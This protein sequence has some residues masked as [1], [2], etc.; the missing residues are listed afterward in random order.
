ME[1]KVFKLNELI[2]PKEEVLRYLG[3]RKQNIDKELNDLI[4]NTIEE[5]KTL[6]AP[7]YIYQ[8]FKTILSDDR[9]GFEGTNLL[10]TGK[11]ISKH[12]KNSQNAIL[13]AV[14]LGSEIQK[15]IAFYE[16]INL[17]K[18]L[19]LDSCATTAVEE[20]CDRIEEHIK[21]QAKEEG[22]S[23]TFRYSPGYG[24]LNITVQKDFLNALNAEKRI[25]LT[26]SESHLLL[27]R[28]SVT[29]IIGLIPKDESTEHNKRNCEVCSN[30]EKCTFRREGIKCG[31]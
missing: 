11:D 26:A 9:V 15:K 29:A 30:Y 20:I 3:Y 18:A 24:D 28:K 7:K 21:A 27:P 16:K 12:L 23:I 22:L 1:N 31:S 5:C 10:L 25:G 19:I 2:I 13:M 17:T 4:D 6:I 14:T 8:K